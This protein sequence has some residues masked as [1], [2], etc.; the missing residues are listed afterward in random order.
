M[1]QN[2]LFLGL[3]TM[4]AAAFAFTSCSSEELQ[5]QNAPQKT[6][7]EISFTYQSAAGTRSVTDPQ[8]NA[9]VSTGLN[10]GIFGVSSEAISTMTN[11][12]NNK[13]VTAAAGAINLA[14]GSSAMTWPI[15]EATASI[16]AYAPYNESWNVNTANAFSV[17]SDQSSDANYLASD[18]LYASAANQAQSTT[19][20]LAFS[21]KL[22]K[23]NI[24][25][26]KLT[27]SNV[28][29]AGAVVK[30]INTKPT[31]SLNPTTGALG[32][33]S[34]DAIE[35]TAATIESEL[36]AGNESSTAN[37]CAVVVPQNLAAE[38]AFVKIVTAG[39]DSKTLIGKLSDA[40]ILE[41]GNSYS[42]TISVGSVTD[43][44]VVVPITLGSTSLVA[45]SDHS[46]GLTAYGVGDFV[47][48]DGTFIKSTEITDAYK[49]LIAGVIF[50]TSVSA[51]DRTAGYNAYAMGLTR[52][53]NRTWGFTDE[54]TAGPTTLAAGLAD[55]DGRTKTSVVVNSSAY[56]TY[57]AS[58]TNH[59]ATL[60]SY[61]PVLTGANMSGWFVPSFGQMVQILNN[62]GGANIS[63]STITAGS[64]GTN[65]SFY[66]YANDNSES[67]VA[68]ATI[69]SNISDYVV[70]KA[71]KSENVLTAGNIT[72]ATISESDGTKFWT[73]ALT[74]NGEG[75]EL[76]AAA[77][78]T[79]NTSRSVIPCFAVAVPAVAQ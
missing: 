73:F 31:T 18:L 22:S 17:Q 26:K 78:K 28:T 23:V 5:S 56:T 74:S 41:S 63:E 39:E 62:L 59:V 3:A 54:I 50:S 20:N 8:P 34:G 44:V 13:Y 77:G 75:W 47:L 76:G 45:W 61:T 38:T 9:T 42:M 27:G 11:Y 19:V 29:L 69:I 55:L 60:S 16:Y 2:K 49:P 40:T 33:A 32:D 1:K 71:G 51:T 68:P 21:H 65:N 57:A 37:A 15:T 4:F 52:M 46:I 70:T 35:I 64:F 67:K 10:V 7:N 24:T 30:I 6:G 72:V 66:V 14:D 58:N 79:S 12:S 53:K 48:A 43:P 36:E 25:I